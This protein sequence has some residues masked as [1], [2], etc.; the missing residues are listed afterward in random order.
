MVGAL[1]RSGFPS[2][3]RRPPTPSPL[4]SLP[5]P[6]TCRPL[7]CG[8]SSWV[9]VVTSCRVLTPP[10]RSWRAR[11]LKPASL[12]LVRFAVWLLFLA[13]T[14]LPSSRAPVPCAHLGAAGSHQADRP[15]VHWRQG[16]PQA[17]MCGGGAHAA[18]DCGPS[19][20]LS[21]A[22]APCSPCRFLVAHQHLRCCCCSF[23]FLAAP[24]FLGARTLTALGLGLAFG[25]GV[26]FG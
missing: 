7:P 17:G 2:V 20:C 1:A 15:Q 5:L 10:V 18:R 24:A 23:P 16:P 14:C 25:E 6:A 11:C 4:S 9:S 19:N 22:A 13:L 26:G 21:L 3:R 12:P 8:S